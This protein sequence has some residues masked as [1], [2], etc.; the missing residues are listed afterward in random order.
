MESQTLFHL[1]TQEMKMTKYKV[2]QTIWTIVQAKDEDEARFQHQQK[3]INDELS[4][5]CWT[6]W[7]FELQNS[8]DED[9]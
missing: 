2:I 3:I 7:E 4:E 6:N 8:D 1:T 5:E 9:E